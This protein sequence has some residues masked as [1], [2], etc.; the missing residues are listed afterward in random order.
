MG[1]RQRGITD[2]LPQTVRRNNA[3]NE[4]KT[5]AALAE[6]IWSS[7]ESGRERRLRLA[8]ERHYG[9]GGQPR[10]PS[11]LNETALSSKSADE[12]PASSQPAEVTAPSQARDEVLALCQP[13]DKTS[14]T[15][16]PTDEVPAASHPTDEIPAANLSLDKIPAPGTP[17]PETLSPTQ[18]SH[19]IPAPSQL[20]DKVPALSQGEQPH[21]PIELSEQ[22][23][24]APVSSGQIFA[25]PAQGEEPAEPLSPNEYASETLL[26]D[27]KVPES[28]EQTAEDLMKGAKSA[29][30]LIP[31]GQSTDT[32][33]R[34]TQP[35]EP[36]VQSQQPA[37]TPSPSKQP[38][39]VPV[40]SEWTPL[41]AAVPSEKPV[42]VLTS[43][44]QL[45]KVPAPS[46]PPAKAVGP[47]ELPAEAPVFIEKPLEDLLP[48]GQLPEAPVPSVRPTEILTPSEQPTGVPVISEQLVETL[49]PSEQAVEVPVQHEQPC[50]AS[51]PNEPPTEASAP[52]EAFTPSEQPGETTT[53][54]EQP[55]ETP[56]PSKQS[57]EAL[58]PCEQLVKVMSSDE[59]SVKVPSSDEQSVKVSSSDEQSVKVLSPDEQSVKVPSSDEQ[60]A[61]GPVRNEKPSE[62]PVQTEQVV[63]ATPATEDAEMQSTDVRGHTSKKKSK[64]AKHSASQQ[65]PP[66]QDKT[67]PQNELAKDQKHGEKV[68]GEK[69]HKRHKGRRKTSEEEP[70][71]PVTPT[72][73]G[74]MGAPLVTDVAAV[75]LEPCTTGRSQAVTD[76]CSPSNGITS[77]PSPAGIHSNGLSTDCASPEPNALEV[78]GDQWTTVETK[79]GK[80]RRKRSE[81]KG[82]PETVT[83]GQE[84]TLDA[85]CDDGLQT[86][87]KTEDAT[88]Q[89][90]LTTVPL[91][92]VDGSLNAQ[93]PPNGTPNGKPQGMEEE[94]SGHANEHLCT[95][96]TSVHAATGAVLEGTVPSEKGVQEPNVTAGTAKD[97]L[98]QLMSSV[99]NL[100]EQFKGALEAKNKRKQESST[101]AESAITRVEPETKPAGICG[102]ALEP[103][104]DVFDLLLSSGDDLN[105]GFE[106]SFT[107]EEPAATEPVIQSTM[108]EASEAEK[109]FSE[110]NTGK[111]ENT[112]H[113][114]DCLT[115]Q[116]DNR[117]EGL[118]PASEKEE[119][120]QAGDEYD[121]RAIK[122]K[123]EAAPD[124]FD[125]LMSADDALG[126]GFKD[127]FESDDSPVPDWRSTDAT[128][129]ETKGQLIHEMGKMDTAPNGTP[130]SA[131][132]D[133]GQEFEDAFQSKDPPIEEVHIR[134]T[135]ADQKLES[136]QESTKK[137]RMEEATLDV[138][139]LL[140]SGGDDL[141]EG[142]KEAF[143]SE[144]TLNKE[145]KTAD[146]VAELIGSDVFPTE[147]MAVTEPDIIDLPTSVGKDLNE[148]FTDAFESEKASIKE[149]KVVDA[150]SD[151]KDSTAPPIEVH[152]EK[153][154]DVFD[155]LM[156]AGDDL[157]E[158]F[159]DAF[160]SGDASIQVSKVACATTDAFANET[161]L[162]GQLEDPKA[163]PDAFDLLLS[164]GDDLE[165]GFKNAFESEDQEKKA[166]ETTATAE[167]IVEATDPK[168]GILNVVPTLDVDQVPKVACATAD[169]FANEKP[170]SEQLEDPKAVPDAFDLLL[171]AGD[172]LEEG[173][174][175]AFESEDQEKKAAE[176]TATAEGIVEATDPKDGILNVVPALDV[177]LDSEC[178]YLKA[179][180]QPTNK[181]S[182]APEET[183]DA[184]ATAK[185]GKLGDKAPPDTTP[186][187]I[188]GPHLSQEQPTGQAGD[189]ARPTLDVSKS[190]RKEKNKGT[191]P[192]AK[193]ETRRVQKDESRISKELAGEDQQDSPDTSE[194]SADQA[195][196]KHEHEPGEKVKTEE[197]VASKPDRSL[198][199]ALDIQGHWWFE[200]AVYDAAEA[201]HYE[202]LSR[203]T[204]SDCTATSDESLIPSNTSNEHAGSDKPEH[205]PAAPKHDE[206]LARS[207]SHGSNKSFP[208][209]EGCC[210]HFSAEDE[211]A[212]GDEVVLCEEDVSQEVWIESKLYKDTHATK[213]AETPAEVSHRP[214]DSATAVDHTLCSARLSADPTAVAEPLT[215][216]PS[217][218]SVNASGPPRASPSPPS[219][220]TRSRRSTFNSATSPLSP[221]AELDDVYFEDVVLAG[222]Q[223]DVTMAALPGFTASPLSEGLA[224]GE[225]LDSLRTEPDLDLSEPGTADTL[226]E[227]DEGGEHPFS[228]D[229][230]PGR[231][232][233]PAA[234]G[235]LA[236]LVPSDGLQKP[237][238]GFQELILTAEVPATELKTDIIFPELDKGV[239]KVALVSEI[240]TPGIRTEIPP[241]SLPAEAEALSQT[242]NPTLIPAADIPKSPMS[243]E[244]PPVS[245]GVDVNSAQ[246][247]REPEP[248]RTAETLASKEASEKAATSVTAGLTTPAQAARDLAP[249]LASTPIQGGARSTPTTSDK[250]EER[251]VH[252]VCESSPM[253]ANNDERRSQE[254]EEGARDNNQPVTSLGADDPKGNEINGKL[255][256]NEDGTASPKDSDEDAL[257][258]TSQ[259][260]P[261]S[262]VAIKRLNRRKKP[263]TGGNRN[264]AAWRERRTS[265]EEVTSLQAEGDTTNNDPTGTAAAPKKS[266]Q[267]VTTFARTPSTDGSDGTQSSN[268]SHTTVIQSEAKNGVV[269]SSEIIQTTS[270]QAANNPAP[271]Q[272]ESSAAVSPGP[273]SES[274]TRPR[275]VGSS[276]PVLADRTLFLP[277]DEGRTYASLMQ[278]GADMQPAR[279]V[280]QAHACHV[281]KRLH[282]KQHRLKSCGNCRLV[283]YCSAEHQR[284]HWPLHR[285][286]CKVI[287]KRMR[288]L[289]TD[290]LYRE[291]LNVASP[292]QWKKI[293]FKHMAVCEEMLDRPMEAYEKEMFLYPR[294]CD[295]C[296]ETNP[297]KLHTCTSCHSVSFCNETHLRKNHGK[298]CKDLRML[299]DIHSH[300][301][302]HGVCDPSLPDTVLTTYEPLPPHIR[303]FLVVGLLGPQRAFSM[304]AVEL[305]V[306]SDCASYPLSLLYALQNIPTTPEGH[307]SQL[308]ELTVHVVGAEF[309]TDCDPIAR[310]DV[311]LLNVLPR[312]RRLHVVFVGPELEVPGSRPGVTEQ[313]FTCAP[314]RAAGKRF[315]CEFQPSTSYHTYC[316]SPQFRPPHAI[317]AFNAGLHRFAGHERRDTWRETLPYLVPDGVPL[318]LTGYT[319]LECPQDVAR[320]QLEQKVDVL[321]PPMK[322]PYRSTRPQQNFLSEHEAPVVFKNQYVACLT[323]AARA[324]K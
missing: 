314:C 272:P 238:A 16:H 113:D 187:P 93:F 243:T 274:G 122:E 54:D 104:R 98:E 324:R 185:N 273:S 175:N 206:S 252:N 216:V 246:A 139:D 58:I 203:R 68:K 281:C 210:E 60:P 125:L 217:E 29:A 127:A 42:E 78:T 244:I 215:V 77:T 88:T 97:A 299:L 195:S 262:P 155:L 241:V 76:Q 22:P 313:D 57:F 254:K 234:H 102:E 184:D 208:L 39:E 114:F 81:R 31:N 151:S 84:Q 90:S 242:L 92:N 160:E 201:R 221:P 288:H 106:E 130:P 123:A 308:T 287:T 94:M 199:E 223:S 179:E 197:N 261:R 105:Q 298:F 4:R 138:F 53:P 305:A 236:S 142:F 45:V 100:R 13:V 46:E 235:E 296:H 282:T 109:V 292:E 306:L 278:Q 48:S 214:P 75:S 111:N 307:I 10:V 136:K 87:V 135:E 116:G 165:E 186:V 205:D 271:V 173:F 304:G 183:A 171:S 275:P 147:E 320:I 209:Y 110:Q 309:A 41:E 318:V 112:A 82:E 145:P 143:E 172:D 295:T 11:K 269:D 32:P 200:K 188:E 158:G 225:Q 240:P 163:V 44:D 52:P 73:G 164:A 61:E 26:P 263:R 213:N 121:R 40:K 9:L 118:A 80:R 34:N 37:E 128:T 38:L 249:V 108:T 211:E 95:P 232:Q 23:T 28:R 284:A 5:M 247:A 132:N 27:A 126:E 62:A 85:P 15:S 251:H 315:T 255:G 181:A 156:S 33:V 170:L 322:N 237:A 141:E 169:A 300:Q 317:C 260:A 291:A 64:K 218:L 189:P 12:I 86:E 55:P 159:K 245:L 47:D 266:R 35:D 302:M 21:E 180:G 17:T 59:Q 14:T 220:G 196:E 256:L 264:D 233:R 297:D 301:N 66:V 212:S 79:K 140:T 316:R 120:A 83:Q 162:T 36:T 167:K 131:G 117:T 25:A 231:E 99:S 194:A 51:A 294:A 311:F 207:S 6:N 56:T 285:A 50:G 103:A 74:E 193:K 24:E 124:A 154:E 257:K 226:D 101:A 166:A 69:R 312:L 250:T 321:L 144:N 7:V 150:T 20:L 310:W 265:A 63:T 279:P 30:T 248:V 190:G 49:I 161:P 19:E 277:S 178:R 8:C 70:D 230:P 268:T 239:T 227:G 259:N 258:F 43:S 134:E 177:D 152:D 91:S 290:H 72:Q 202:A 276:R 115:I 146:N 319:L 182:K 270:R 96:M 2:T 71:I 323:A 176:T 280:F 222:R 3:K 149:T 293:R 148:G 107:F 137:P 191:R 119:I 89:P 267:D 289:G 168:D 229:S 198:A 224:P 157:E 219:D 174:K 129:V 1:R 286:L 204:G 228:Y 65:D 18:L 253:H 192:K 283:A 303:E 133:S 67:I 153:T